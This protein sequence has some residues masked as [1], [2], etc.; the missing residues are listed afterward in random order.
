MQD[1]IVYLVVVPVALVVGAIIGHFITRYILEKQIKKWQKK[2][3]TPDKKQVRNM[4]SA[5]GRKPSEEQ[6]NRFINMTK[7]AEKKKPQKPKKVSLKK[8]K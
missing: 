5:L 4:L 1:L 3:E 2:M 7:K 6:V 8:K